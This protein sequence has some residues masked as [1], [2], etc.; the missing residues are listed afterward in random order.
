LPAYYSDNFI[1]LLPG[2]SREVRIEW[3]AGGPENVR[4]DL[5]GWNVE[6]VGIDDNGLVKIAH[7]AGG[8]SARTN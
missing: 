3:K 1:S 8:M 7:N 4:V 2:E 6:A 5:D